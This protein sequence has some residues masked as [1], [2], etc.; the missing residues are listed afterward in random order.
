MKKQM[1]LKKLA[2]LIAVLVFIFSMT[3]CSSTKIVA[4]PEGV[5]E[6]TV[7]AYTENL[8]SQ[9]AAMTPEQMDQMINARNEEISEDTEM[10][11]LLKRAISAWQDAQEDLGAYV[12][13]D[14][15]EI[16][17]GNDTVT[18]T[19]KLTFE[20]RTADFI[21]VFD[22][23]VTQYEAIKIEPHFS[24]GEKMANAG[25]NTL[26]GMGVVF[27]VLIFIAFLISRF[28]YIS[29]FENYLAHRRDAKNKKDEVFVPKSADMAP[30]VLDSTPV[31]EEISDLELVAVITAAVA[32]SMN[33]SV[34]SLVVRSIRKRKNNR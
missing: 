20:K 9:F 15:F 4:L 16:A 18:G 14:G 25:L 29:K 31:P 10:A 11:L 6:A 7:Q 26:M 27:I 13:T 30:V 33:T 12:S 32:A 19:L 3:A 28:K 1:T 17:S 34:D 8:Y 21:V 22:G 24:T 23:D 5:D 2:A